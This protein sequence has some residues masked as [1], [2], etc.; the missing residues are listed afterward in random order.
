MAPAYR[1]GKGP[2]VVAIEQFIAGDENDVRTWYQELG[3][4]AGFLEQ[5]APTTFDKFLK[6]TR[7]GEYQHL[8][9]DVF[10]P[11]PNVV[12]LPAADVA[13]A[14]AAGLSRRVVYGQGLRR[15]LELAWGLGAPGGEYPAAER[16]TIDVYWSCGQA[17]NLVGIRTNPA[18][19]VVTVLIYSD[20]AAAGDD[21]KAVLA[22]DP[23][24]RLQPDPAGDLFLVDDRKGPGV[25]S[26]WRATTRI[27]LATS[28]APQ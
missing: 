23:T 28:P 25:V 18:R 15:A 12:G 8:T 6:N 11:G 17:Y 16:W 27:G 24:K 22:V 4:E 19:K 7:P 10:G 3:D 21:P 14:Q 5:L 1:I 20:Q 9:E 26:Q 2:I 13:A